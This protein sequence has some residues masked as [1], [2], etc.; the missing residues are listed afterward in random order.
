MSDESLSAVSVEPEMDTS[1]PVEEVKQEAEDNGADVT[2]ANESDE[3]PELSEADKVKFAMQKR[4][5]RQTA[6]TKR[7]EEELA[8]ARA[9]VEKFKTQD[10]PK[11]EAED[12]KPREEDFDSLDEWIN[13]TAEW[14]AET[15]AEKRLSEAKQKQLQEAQQK[16]FELRQAQFNERINAF[17]AD[18]PDYP[19]R[20]LLFSETVEDLQD[21]YGASPTLSV[22]GDYIQ[23]SDVAPSLIYELGSNPELA[24]DLAGMQPMQALEE[25]VKLKLSVQNR[26]PEK[27]S[28]KPKPIKPLNST[29]RS[30]K[31]LDDMSPSELMAHMAS[32]RK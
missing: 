18:F 19:E 21:K 13:A 24:H 11:Q 26:K 2:E 16:E 7:M 23:Q 5:D 15:L 17:K 4:I 25:L 32:L 9:E 29:G 10:A 8:Q 6:R 20:E 31:K 27:A 14:K 12:G 1:N 28:E 3:Q 22:L 30:T